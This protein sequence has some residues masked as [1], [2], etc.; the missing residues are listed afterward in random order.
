M[1]IFETKVFV[2]D[3]IILSFHAMMEFVRENYPKVW[4]Q[5][6]GELIRRYQ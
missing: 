2:C 1:S 4:E 5:S 6:K 3:H